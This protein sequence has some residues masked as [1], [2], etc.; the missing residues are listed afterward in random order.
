ML[1]K[2]ISIKKRDRLIAYT[3]N[4]KLSKH[5]NIAQFTIG[6]VLD[7]GKCGFNPPTKKELDKM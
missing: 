3:H 1:Q 4:L 5:M 7:C 6:W 2:N